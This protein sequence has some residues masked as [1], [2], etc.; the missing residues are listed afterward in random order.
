MGEQVTIQPP[1]LLVAKPKKKWRWF[2]I[3]AGLILGVVVLLKLVDGY[4]PVELELRR[5]NLFDAA[6]DGRAVEII[7]VGKESLKIMNITIN[8][9][10]DVRS[11]DCRLLMD[12]N[13]SQP[14]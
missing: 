9:R 4:N 7:N 6:R 2:M 5:A 1:P 3:T 11:V 12:L 8:E 10:A 13:R 14:T